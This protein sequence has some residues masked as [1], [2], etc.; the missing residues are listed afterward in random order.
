[1]GKPRQLTHKTKH[2]RH[3]DVDVVRIFCP[4]YKTICRVQHS[5]GNCE[6]VALEFP[7]IKPH[8]KYNAT[9]AKDASTDAAT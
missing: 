4:Q 3:R 1:M 2:H 6:K 7:R 9:N 8:N 5:A